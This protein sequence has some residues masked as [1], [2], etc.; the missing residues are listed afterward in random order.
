MVKAREI[1]WS[2]YKGF[3]GPFF[4]G[5]Y[6]FEVPEFPLDSDAIVA[7]ISATEG[8]C[9]DSYNGYDGQ[10]CSFGLIQVTE[11]AYYQVSK[12]LGEVGR[13]DP[14][15]LEPLRLEL[16]QKGLSFRP[17]PRGRWRFFFRD[18]RGEVDVR[19]EQQRMFFYRST[20]ERGSWDKAS[21]RYAKE[22][23][24]AIC[25]VMENPVAQAIQRDF[26]SN[27][28]RQYAFG[29]SKKFLQS[30]PES[31]LGAAFTAAYLSFAVNNP[32]RANKHLS[33]A[34]KR[35]RHAR[36]GLSWFIDVLKELTFGPKISIYPH[37]YDAI[38]EPL[39]RL[40]NLNLPDMADELIPW[41]EDTGHIF[42]F[43]A[44]EVQEALIFL[45]S[46]LGPRGAD[47]KWGRKSRGAMFAFEESHEVPE[48][49]RDG[50]PDP[51]SMEK[52]RD[53]LQAKGYAEL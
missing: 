1:G 46:D 45:G 9:Y 28:V 11:R 39:E 19:E 48:E 22:M 20:G 31:D 3:E 23:A 17:N 51:I 7:V 34:L 2:S 25:T 24:A 38:R 5:R 15:L 40:Y 27:R 8:G 6:R 33:I 14:E 52:L 4:R 35:S 41:I 13:R 43:N 47:G 12:L 42:G 53:A 18:S 29:E 30:A 44:T 49:L 32:V 37:R 21:K 50:M 26:V 16:T 36:W 10:D